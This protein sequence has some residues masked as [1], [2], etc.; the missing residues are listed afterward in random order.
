MKIPFQNKVWKTKFQQFEIAAPTILRRTK[1]NPNRNSMNST[2]IDRR[3]ER[4]ELN[5]LLFRECTF[6]LHLISIY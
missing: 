6:M 5:I 1:C 3:R 4:N 2:R